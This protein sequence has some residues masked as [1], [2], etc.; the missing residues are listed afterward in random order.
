M[1]HSLVKVYIHYVWTTKYRERTLLAEARQVLK[2]HIEEYSAENK[3]LIDTLHIQPE[4]VHALIML[5]RDQ[6][7]EDVAK[8][9]KGESS[10]WMNQNDVL[11]V[12]FSWQTGYA[13][14]SLDY[15]GL[16]AVRYYIN[17]QEEH[18][19]RKSFKEEFESMLR[20]HGYSAEEIATLLDEGNR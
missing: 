4:H 1:A 5:K 8:L 10:H 17:N 12:K 20:D 2:S 11:P 19:R 14:F 16:D 13:A 9:L 15:Q 7:I 3:I 18:H 6:R